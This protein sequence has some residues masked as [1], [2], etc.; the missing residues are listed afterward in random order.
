[1]RQAS[2]IKDRDHQ[3]LQ[4]ANVSL[5]VCVCVCVCMCSKDNNVK[6]KIQKRKRRRTTF[7]KSEHLK[8]IYIYR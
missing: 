6:E 8:N 1:M 4:I 3:P 7:D 2:K 5:R